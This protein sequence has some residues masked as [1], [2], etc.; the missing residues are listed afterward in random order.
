MERRRFGSRRGERK[1]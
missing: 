1:E